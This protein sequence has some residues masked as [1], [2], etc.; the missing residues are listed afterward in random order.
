MF[1]L[2]S[3]FGR[4]WILTRV[5]IL[6]CLYVNISW[7]KRLAR[8]FGPLLCGSG[9]TQWTI[10]LLSFYTSGLGVSGLRDWKRLHLPQSFAHSWCSSSH[11]SRCVDITCCQRRHYR[12]ISVLS[13]E[14]LKCFHTSSLSSFQSGMFLLGSSLVPLCKSFCSSSVFLLE[15]Q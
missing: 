5:K 9:V 6:L 14:D 3:S 4:F 7:H 1:V 10:F 2:G 8:F 13:H 12:V 11:G 15:N